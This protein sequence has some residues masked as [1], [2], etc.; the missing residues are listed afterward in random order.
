M[1]SAL[2]LW[3]EESGLTPRSI[4]PLPGDLSQRQYFRVELAAGGSILVAKYPSSMAASQARFLASRRLLDDAG[5]AVPEV[6]ASS[7][8]AGFMALEDLGEKT[9]H[10]L[11]GDGVAI[12]P[13]LENALEQRQR[14]AALDPNAVRALGN[15]AL[16]APLLN[17]EVDLTFAHLFEPRGIAELGPAA[18]EFRSALADLCNELGALEPVPCHRDFMVRNLMPRGASEVVLLDFQD[19]RPGPP[20]YDLA[21]LLNDS[22][23]APAEFE[24]R[25]VATFAPGRPGLSAYRRAVVQR[26]LK[27]AGTFARFAAGGNPRHLPLIAPILAR[28]EP[29]LARLPETSRAF[30]RIESWWRERLSGP[31]FC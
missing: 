16:D 22:W 25:T 28:V 21:S 18:R 19:L 1:E 30:R 6:L 10:D 24:E 9:L 12:G 4:V 27:A 23:S 2:P 15:P 14:I 8:A 13:F 31:G 20:T 3:L 26:G 17:R 29:H 5:I 7:D 11:A